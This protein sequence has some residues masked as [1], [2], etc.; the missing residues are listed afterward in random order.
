MNQDNNQSQINV[1]KPDSGFSLNMPKMPGIKMPKMNPK[2][3][4][5]LT[6]F[7]AIISVVTAILLYKNRSQPQVPVT[8]NASTTV[9]I[10]DQFSGTPDTTF[11]DFTLQGGAT[12]NTTGG[13]LQFNI[14]DQTAE[15]FARATT[16]SQFQGD[17]SAE[18]DLLG[19]TVNGTRGSA[20]LFFSTDTAGIARIARYKHADGSQSI[21]SQF[22]TD[23]K[24][25]ESIPA[26]TGT[27]KVKIN[28]V[29]N[30]IQT[31]Y[32]LGSGYQLLGTKIGGET[33]NGRFAL[34]AFSVTPDFPSV[35]SDFDN[36]TARV[37]PVGA[38]APTPGTA[39]ACIVSFQVLDIVPTNTPGPTATPS[40]TPTGT[41]GPTATPTPGPTATP[42]P[43]PTATPT[44][45][46]PNSCG[47]TCGSN[48]NCDSSH[49]CF[50]GF[51]R[52]PQCTS[53]STCVCGGP[54]STPTLGTTPTPTTAIAMVPTPTPVLLEKSGSVTGTW[55]LAIGG[56]VL[57]G[58]GSVLFLAL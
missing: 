55:I 58:L 30:V 44:P 19:V 9:T 53:S 41:P 2:L 43:G 36:F 48:A 27:I 51:C 7:L 50:Q 28:R 54:T 49:V 22:G 57:L 52:N 45:G 46:Q 12:Q 6:V 11:W 14:P 56:A 40:P 3:V 10:T 42:T 15:T 33:A 1:I 5:I 23:T 20:E 24:V 47:G 31:F 38:P 37:N 32:D 4:G 39:T 21:E 25:A 26:A 17:F 16:R 29:G 8:A 18:V 35:I 34:A 13:K